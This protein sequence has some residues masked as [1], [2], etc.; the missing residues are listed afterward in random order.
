MRTFL[1]LISISLL[2]IQCKKG[3][4]STLPTK[5]KKNYGFIAD[6]AMVVSAREEASKIGVSIMKQ[7]GNAF[8]AMVATD[9]ALLVSFPFAGNIG[10][11][12]F[13]VYRLN[14]GE[15]GCLDYREKAPF[16]ASRDMY[17]DKDGNI[18][19]NKS[20][21]GAMAV[22]VPGTVAG[23]FEA[24]KKFGTMPIEKLI[25]PA[26]D[27]ATNGVVVTKNQAR[28]FRAYRHLFK[29]AN[30]RTIF[31]DKDWQVG[32]TIKYSALAK[33]LTRIRDNGKDEF[34]KGKTADMLVEYVQSL[35]GIITKEDLANYEAKW[36]DPITFTYKGNKIISMSPPSSGGICVAQILKSI[37]PYNINQYKHNSLEYIQLITE[38]ERRTYADRSEFLGDPDF[39]NIPID[40]LIS[41][42]YLAQRM[43]DFSWDKATKSSDISY[44]QI[45]LPESEETTHYSIVDQFGNA[46]AVTTTINGAYGS[47]VY[48]K[49]AGFFLNNEMDDFSSKPGEPNM[50][51]LLGAEA[52]AIAPQKRMLSAMTPTIVEKDGN[53]KM[54]IGTPGGSTI[55]TS[56]MQ[57]ILNVLEYD[58]TMQES[59][60][61]PRFHHQWYPDDIK[62]ETS[63]DTLV[64]KDL[65]KKGY[66]IDQSDSRII[67]KVDAILVLPNGKLEGGA[68]PRGDDSAVGF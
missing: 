61:Q 62:F 17:L 59:V 50:F 58:M 10:G 49:D 40:T 6:S 31:L 55:I 8:D 16:A 27:L 7:G 54:V 24:H 18:I 64:F 34:Y 29:K 47:K 43:S 42:Y 11:G 26:I 19:P 63:F 67:G 37:E 45:T 21:L 15:T 56:V 46:V 36:R 33:T 52:N 38:A 30:N 13:M 32:D 28:M 20:T 22:G 9:L 68:D 53:L 48:V 35:G 1:I 65:R 14:N 57:N 39:V 5:T 12:G 4:P 41:P 51:G 2:T 60:S 66:S 44:G 23:L 25:Q 3:N